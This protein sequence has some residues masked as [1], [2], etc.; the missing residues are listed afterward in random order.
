MNIE[1]SGY[2]KNKQLLILFIVLFPFIVNASNNQNEMPGLKYLFY[3]MDQNIWH[4]F[5]NDYG[6]YHLAAAGLSYG[7]VQS[8][9]DWKYRSFMKRNPSIP[10][11]GFASVFTGEFMP[12]VAPLYLYITGRS[13]SNSKMVYTSMA[14]GQSVLLSVLISSTYKAF[15]G[16]GGPEISH[17]DKNRSDFSKDFHFGFLRGGVYH[18]WPSSHTT[19]AFAMATTLIEMYPDNNTVKI[20]SGLYAFAV[21]LGV[22]T[23]IHWFSDFVAGALI[24]YSI[25]KSVGQSFKDLA[26]GKSEQDKTSFYLTPNG[27]RFTVRF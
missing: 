14:L 19:N 11:I 7:L 10:R 5:S 8:D 6:V 27:F 26:D 20:F 13:N 12:V 1:S 23:N 3:H 17:R 15:T 22:S 21:G 9:F 16:R 24:G 4:S 18:G 2:T 25:G